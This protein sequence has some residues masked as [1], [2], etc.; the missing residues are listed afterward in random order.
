MTQYTR[1]KLH[2][3]E[4]IE[5]EMSKIGSEYSVGHKMFALLHFIV[6]ANDTR[7]CFSGGHIKLDQE[8]C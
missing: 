2:I 1:R 6:I 7:S 4:L 8:F 3:A 5:Y